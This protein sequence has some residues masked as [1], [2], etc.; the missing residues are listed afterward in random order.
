MRQTILLKITVDLISR[1]SA[2]SLHFSPT[3]FFQ[4][5]F[6]FKHFPAAVQHWD[7]GEGEGEE[8][9]LPCVSAELR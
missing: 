3:S 4:N 9:V 6:F 2:L 7:P 5:F 8:D 1:V